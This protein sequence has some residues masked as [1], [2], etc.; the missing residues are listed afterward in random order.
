M[1][2]KAQI[3][4]ELTAY[5]RDAKKLDEKLD[6]LP[7]P[8]DTPEEPDE[9][10]YSKNKK[11]KSKIL[12]PQTTDTQVASVINTLE[13]AWLSFKKNK[14]AESPEDIMEDSIEMGMANLK[15]LTMHLQA[16]IVMLQVGS[17]D[18][19]A[20]PWVQEKI[21]LSRDY[22]MA[23]HDYVSSEQGSEEEEDEEE[24]D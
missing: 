20:E 3:I 15:S 8:A 16:L 11:N 1:K 24:E 2:T 7:E 13:S 4:E 10:T 5:A 17:K 22:I 14:A 9:L 21:T 19:L 18:C 23:V 6:Q 12:L